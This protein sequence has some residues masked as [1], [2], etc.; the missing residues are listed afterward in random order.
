MTTPQYQ[1]GQTVSL[2]FA[3][4]QYQGEVIEA[5]S[6]TC[7]VFDEDGL[8][9]DEGLILIGY[10]AGDETASVEI[11]SVYH[12]VTESMVARRVEVVFDTLTSGSYKVTQRYIVSP[13]ATLVFLSNS[14]AIY[15]RFLIIRQEFPELLGWDAT[16]EDR[17]T[18]ALIQAHEN[19]C[20]F[21][22][23]YRQ[24]S[25][26][27][28]A[29]QSTLYRRDYHTFIRDMRIIEQ[30]DW[31]DFPPHFQLSLRR[32]QLLEADSLLNGDPI[33]DKREQGIVSETVGESK[34][35]FNNRPPLRMGVSRAALDHLKR[36]IFL[37]TTVSR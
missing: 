29:S 5:S 11:P 14:F 22:F 15:E 9:V 26:Q 8:E 34:M 21:K 33:R 37:R 28:V 10:T 35:F 18:A 20:R 36:Y 2:S 6:V 32:A 16:D 24:E 13:D 7:K 12:A 23:K 31:D 17:R 4:P 1:P 27:P 3:V 25:D 30:E 19:I